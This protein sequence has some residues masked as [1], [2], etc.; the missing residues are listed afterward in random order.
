M[1]IICL[2][3][4]LFLALTACSQPAGTVADPAPAG[5]FAPGNEGIDL[6]HHN[7]R[8]NW[9]ALGSA[10]IDFVYLKA[11]E[12]RDWKDTRFQENWREA[13][14]RGWHVGAYHFYLLCKNGAAQ[15][16]NFIQSVEVR[17]GTLPPAVDLEYAHNCTPD[18]PKAAVLAE[19]D[20]FLTALEAEYGAPPVLY[21]TPEFHRDWLAGRFPRNPVWMRRLSGPPEGEVL[22]WQYSMKG[23]VPGVD[24]FV[25]LNR[26][27][28]ER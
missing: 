26:I 4:S 11:T 10:P 28:D 23:R 6:S 1:R 14:Q 9:E 27:P 2:I 7:G 20:D 21:T 18:G 19:I 13:S 16:E 17:D 3:G 25:D 12:G 15:A 5:A 22:I 8:V 24:G